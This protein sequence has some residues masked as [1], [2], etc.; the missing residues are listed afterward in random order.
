MAKDTTGPACELQPRG[1]R[2]SPAQSAPLGFR[3]Q[4]PQD[5]RTTEGPSLVEAGLVGYKPGWGLALHRTTLLLF[6]Q[7]KE[8]KTIAQETATSCKACSVTQEPPKSMKTAPKNPCLQNSRYSVEAGTGELS[9]LQTSPLA[10]GAKGRLS[11]PMTCPLATT[12][13]PQGSHHLDSLRPGQLLR[14]AA[15]RLL[16]PGCCCETTLP[17]LHGALP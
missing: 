9:H 13:T 2:P 4:D 11:P 15:P 14:W 10:S 16:G 5:A 1:R 17:H 7:A 12:E 8:R 6:T 3:D